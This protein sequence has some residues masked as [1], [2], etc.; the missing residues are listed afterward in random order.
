MSW[1]VGFMKIYHLIPTKLFSKTQHHQNND[2][3]KVVNIFFPPYD[4]FFIIK[5]VKNE[6]TLIPRLIVTFEKIRWIIV[7]PS[8]LSLIKIRVI[9]KHLN[10][11]ML[12]TLQISICFFLLNAG[13]SNIFLF[14]YPKLIFLQQ[15]SFP[16]FITKFT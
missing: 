9:F 4:Y 6:V 11:S 8:T 15:F 16:I 3:L 1:I 10:E 2:M 7:S 13:F 12:S 5:T 14:E